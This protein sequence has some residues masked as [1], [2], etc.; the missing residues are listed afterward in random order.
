MSKLGDVIDPELRQ[1]LIQWEHLGRRPWIVKPKWTPPSLPGMQP[2]QNLI[3]QHLIPRLWQ[4]LADYQELLRKGG[5]FR[6]QQPGWLEPAWSADPLDICSE[7][8]VALVDGTPVEV[9]SF[10]VPDRHVASLRWFGHGLDQGTEWGTVVW[11]I[12]VNDK[13]V[14][15]YFKFKQQR[16]LYVEPTRLAGPIKLKGK[17]VI[18]LLATGGSTDVNATGRLQGWL[19]AAGAVTQDGTAADWNVR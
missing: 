4:L 19:V 6:V 14:R 9:L 12:T 3:D 2:V 8:P 16:G 17:D 5:S 1:I 11:T 10:Q 7:E 15:T 13:P 18:K